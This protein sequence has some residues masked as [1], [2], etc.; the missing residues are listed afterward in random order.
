MGQIYKT[1]NIPNHISGIYKI[2]FPNGKSYIGLSNNIKRRIREHNYHS[3]ISDNNS[4]KQSVHFAIQKYFNGKVSEIEILEEIE[5]GNKEKMKER[6]VYW[7]A[8]YDTFNEDNGYNLTEGGDGIEMLRNLWKENEK[9]TE[10]QTEEVRDLLK[11]SFLT[12][13]E[14]AEKF[15]VEDSI[16]KYINH[17]ISHYNPEI[18]YPIR[19]KYLGSK[20]KS[21]RENNYNLITDELLLKIHDLLLNSKLTYE[22][23]ASQLNINPRLMSTINIGKYEYY[24]LEGY[25][26][27]L[28]EKAII[29]TSGFDSIHSKLTRNE[30]LEIL[31]LL[32]N[33]D[34]MIKDIAD[35]YGVSRATISKVNQGIG[36]FIE[37]V[38]Y[39]IREVNEVA[40]L[41]NNEDY[42]YEII[43]L[44]KNSKY[45][46]KEIG[47]RYNLC[48]QSISDINVGKSHKLEGIEYPIRNSKFSNELIDNVIILLKQG[49]SYASIGR[50]L[51]L[52]GR[53]VKK[54]NLGQ[55]YK[56][57][58]EDYPI[59]K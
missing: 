32:K 44:L 5:Y 15:N 56:R 34:M 20:L 52:D 36:Y 22:E 25:N 37:R 41:K 54:I 45:S 35:I 33:S 9:L 3:K 58:N 24:K 16:I 12:Q 42:V 53:T 29:K 46:M 26:Y 13:K 49:K 11:N 2:N 23:I 50:D 39:P 21:I 6:E 55:I 7:I 38:E 31:S 17:G 27:P 59:K 19:E 10:E 51:N 30:V 48:Q 14:I 57:D 18:N 4:N 43:D 40:K 28:R 47:K 8:Y 1:E